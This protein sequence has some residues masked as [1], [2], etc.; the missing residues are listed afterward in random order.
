MSEKTK[1]LYDPNTG[2]IA[3]VLVQAAMGG[4]SFIPNLF[5]TD[6]W[7][8]TPTPNMKMMSATRSQWDQIAKMTRQER[9][10]R[11]NNNDH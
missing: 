4:N 2:K 9:I 5:K 1:A 11:W 6:D 8:L 7:E 10:N 3:C